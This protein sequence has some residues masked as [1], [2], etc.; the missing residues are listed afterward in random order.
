MVDPDMTEHTDPAVQIQDDNALIAQRRAMLAALRE[1]GGAF[2]VDFRRYG[3]AG[4]L[5]AEYGDKDAAHLEAHP[6]RV[7]VAGRMMAKRLMGKA[8][9]TQLLD[10]SGRIQLFIQ[11]DALPEGQY[12][13]IKGWDVGDIIGVV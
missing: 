10:M 11:R 3:M 13:E 12:E 1:Q 5:H 8:S 9:F 4:E 7:K 6:L 2:P